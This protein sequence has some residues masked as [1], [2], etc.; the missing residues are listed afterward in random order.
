MSKVTYIYNDKTLPMSKTSA[1]HR[2]RRIETKKHMAN[3]IKRG[4][5][6]DGYYLDKEIRTS[7]KVTVLVPEETVKVCVDKYHYC[8]FG[9]GNFDNCPLYETKVVPE[10]TYTYHTN[11][12]YVDRKSPIVRRFDY[13]NIKKTI[14]I[15]TNRKNRH[16]NIPIYDNLDNYEDDTIITNVNGKTYKNVIDNWYY[17]E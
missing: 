1:I 11:G 4:K 15:L 9:N 2:N 13:G 12:H 14:K 16:V 6:Y 7:N 3:L 10:H 17:I 8:R 5:A